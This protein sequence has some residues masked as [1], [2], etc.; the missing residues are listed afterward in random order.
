MV[1][2]SNCNHSFNE[3]DD[4]C[5]KCA[6]D[7][8][9]PNVRAAAAEAG[10]LDKRYQTA[11]DL[12]R[13]QGSHDSLTNFEAH[14]QRTFAVINVKL[15]FLYSFVSDDKLLYTNYHRAVSSQTRKAAEAEND[16]HRTGVDSR[17]FGSYSDKI[18]HAALSL[19]GRGPSY[20]T[21]SL[22][23]EDIAI[24]DRASLLEE[25]S[26]DFVERRNLKKGRIPP[27]Y[28]SVWQE[29]HKLAV[30]KLAANVSGTTIEKEYPY[31][32]LPASSGRSTDEYIEVHIF[33]TFDNSAIESVRG[34][35]TLRTKAER[36]LVE[37]AKAYVRKAGKAWVEE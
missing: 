28:R 30:A 22:R 4:R 34:K 19:D 14:M 31:L 18:I 37:T 10:A 33:G 27:G 7:V 25:N 36:A 3:A 13:K 11:F 26:Y 1:R 23:L 16:R 32:L 24:K 17:I 12:A 35:S 6:A 5:P 2:C 15:G 29:R 8:G 9:F 21:Y 20:G